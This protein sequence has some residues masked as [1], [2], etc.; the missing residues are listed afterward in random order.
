MQERVRLCRGEVE[1]S[2]LREFRA[3]FHDA[4]LNSAMTDLCHEYLYSIS[5]LCT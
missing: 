3:S 5:L 1:G 4:G 2:S